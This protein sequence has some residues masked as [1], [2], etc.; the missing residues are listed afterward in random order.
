[1]FYVFVGLLNLALLFAGVS[2][3][4]DQGRFFEAMGSLLAV[5][6]VVWYCAKEL[7]KR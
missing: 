2:A 5:A 3:L 1:M 7:L 6:W 4:L